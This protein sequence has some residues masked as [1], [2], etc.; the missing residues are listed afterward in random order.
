VIVVKLAELLAAT[1][2]VRTLVA[3]IAAAT[4]LTANNAAVSKLLASAVPTARARV[5]ARWPRRT[6]TGP[7]GLR[8]VT[9]LSPGCRSRRE[10]EVRRPAA[11]GHGF[12]AAGVTDEATAGTAAANRGST[13]NFRGGPSQVARGDPRWGRPQV[14]AHVVAER[15]SAQQDPGS[16]G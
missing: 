6:R 4:A 11:E 1:A 7:A 10:C 5:R 16:F 13:P 12:P 9:R 2:A 14:L 3:A 15:R 8:I